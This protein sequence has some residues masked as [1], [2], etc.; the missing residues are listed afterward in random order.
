MKRVFFHIH[1]WKTGGVSFYSICRRNFGRG[2]HRDSMLI[3]NWYL[4]REQLEW[5]L[6]YHGWLRC[7][8]CHM[9]SGDLPYERKS[10]EVIGVAFVREPVSR[11]VSSYNF[12][13][14]DT[15]LGG[16]AKSQA[17]G[18]FVRN[19]LVDV[20]N[21]WWRDGQ[22]FALGGSGDED[23][24]RRIRERVGRGQLILLP[25]ERFD[26]SCLLLEQLFPADFRDCRYARMN[27]SQRRDTDYEMQRDIIGRYMRA[28]SALWAYANDFLDSKLQEYFPTEASRNDHLR[29]FR[30]RCRRIPALERLG[31]FDKRLRRAAKGLLTKLAGSK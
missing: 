3:Q 30:R 22:T 2:F 14:G 27:V 18:D 20:N 5:L 8:S 11:F 4:S 19:A 17:F 6:D 31:I 25:T 1:I 13:R 29:K 23:G 26:E 24:L 12:Q 10:E 9:L 21:P 28:D 15:Y 7:Y 16:H